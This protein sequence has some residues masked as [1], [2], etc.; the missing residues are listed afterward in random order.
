M[1]RSAIASRLD[2]AAYT[3]A[4]PADCS[5][6][7]VTCASSLIALAFRTR[8]H[9]TGAINNVGKNGQLTGSEYGSAAKVQPGN[10]GGV[11]AGIGSHRLH[12]LRSIAQERAR[13]SGA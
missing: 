12:F 1:R 10:A 3:A 4:R 2:M 13:G 7:P 5:A 6:I 8:R 9:Y 11:S